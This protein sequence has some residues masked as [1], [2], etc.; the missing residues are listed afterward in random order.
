MKCPRCKASMR[1]VIEP[2]YMRGVGIQKCD[3]CW[4]C[5]SC[6]HREYKPAPEVTS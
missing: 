4:K 3:A 6:G 2:R 5:W 1:Y